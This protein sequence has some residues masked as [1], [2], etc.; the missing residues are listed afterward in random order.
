MRL[1][2]SAT[3]PYANAAVIFGYP[4]RKENRS[5]C[6]TIRLSAKDSCVKFYAMSNSR[7]KNLRNYFNKKPARVARRRL[8]IRNWWSSDTYNKGIPSSMLNS[9][10]AISFIK[11]ENSWLCEYLRHVPLPSG[12]RTSFPST[13]FARIHSKVTFFRTILPP[14]IMI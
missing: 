2:K 8:L 11:S 14:L 6:R 9:F 4:V 10:F 5:P 12:Y 7:R 13:F 1:R 3:S